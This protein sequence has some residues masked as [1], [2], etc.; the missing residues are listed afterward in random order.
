[1]ERGARRMEILITGFKGNDNSTKLLLDLIS[2][3][4]NVDKLYLENDFVPLGEQLKQH[5]TKKKYDYIFLFGQKPGLKEILIEI[6][7]VYGEEVCDTNFSYEPLLEE[8]KMYGYEG[9]ISYDAG[10]SL[11]NY[12]YYRGLKL[13][14]EETGNTKVVMIRIPKLHEIDIMKF[15]NVWST[16]LKRYFV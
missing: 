5:I 11:C 13:V 16:I 15:A 2:P 14:E 3:K 10:S 7:A 1:M 8:L 6:R 9:S 4:Y 12:A